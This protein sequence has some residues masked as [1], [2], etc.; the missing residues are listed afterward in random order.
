MSARRRPWLGDER[1]P[2]LE[3]DELVVIKIYE[4]N[5]W[6]VA[7]FRR[8]R[9]PSR[10]AFSAQSVYNKGIYGIPIGD[11][12]SACF[13]MNLP[14]DRAS[15]LVYLPTV[16]QGFVVCQTSPSASTRSA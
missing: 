15:E 7:F 11:I 10:C 4:S 14:H 1:R 13:I 6:V 2:P 9:D 12:G 8:V 5:M 3:N 16:G